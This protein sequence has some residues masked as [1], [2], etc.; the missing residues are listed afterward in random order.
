ME[1]YFCDCLSG[2]KVGLSNQ[3]CG[4][5]Q[6]EKQMENYRGYQVMGENKMTILDSYTTPVSGTSAGRQMSGDTWFGTGVSD[7][8]QLSFIQ[9]I[10]RLEDGV[11]LLKEGDKIYVFRYKQ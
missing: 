7:T 2:C 6:G 4:D 10:C 1:I 11:R 5:R 3:A 8:R 9:G